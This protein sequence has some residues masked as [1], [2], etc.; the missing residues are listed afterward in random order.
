MRERLRHSVCPDDIQRRVEQEI[1][2][3]AGKRLQGKSDCETRGQEIR[4]GVSRC[5]KEELANLLLHKDAMTQP[6]QTVLVVFPV[7]CQR[8]Q[9]CQFIVI[10]NMTPIHTH[11][12]LKASRICITECDYHIHFGSLLRGHVFQTYVSLADEIVRS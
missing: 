6:V 10:G 12:C 4:D 11:N 9:A 1:K 8:V 3:A 7:R 2:S 5:R